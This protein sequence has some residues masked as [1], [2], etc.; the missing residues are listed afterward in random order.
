MTLSDL[1][2]HRFNKQV[3]WPRWASRLVSEFVDNFNESELVLSPHA[4]EKLYTNPKVKSQLNK[5]K[6]LILR[7]LYEG[8]KLD[9]RNVFEFYLGRDM[10]VK[11]I[12]HRCE[13]FDTGYDIILV[14]AR[15]GIVVTLYINK[16][17][18]VHRNLNSGNYFKGAKND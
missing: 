8:L 10:S 5:K 7:Y 11:K 16:S 6:D 15:N 2:P 12:C 3:Y 9:A 18:Y 13:L 1:P 14:V 4:E 17:N